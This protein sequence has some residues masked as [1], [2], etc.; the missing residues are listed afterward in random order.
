MANEEYRS[1]GGP[2]RRQC[3][4]DKKTLVC[5]NCGLSYKLVQKE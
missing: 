5:N 1:V 3:D 4:V 2:C